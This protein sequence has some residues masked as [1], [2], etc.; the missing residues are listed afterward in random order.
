MP[1]YKRKHFKDI[2]KII[3]KLPVEQRKMIAIDFANLFSIE[4]QNFNR[5]MFM[6]ECG[7]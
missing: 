6:K 5:N 1:S 7:L 3:T 2:A 4:N